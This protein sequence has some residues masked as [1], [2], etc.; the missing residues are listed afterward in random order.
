MK[1]TFKHRKTGE[2]AT[3]E[4]G[5]LKS[6]GFCVELGV[7]PS[8][9]LWE[10]VIEKDY[11]ILS[12]QY[13]GEYQI[14]T[15]KENIDSWMHPSCRGNWEIYSIKRLSD[16]E[17]FTVGDK[18]TGTLSLFEPQKGYV[19]ITGFRINNNKLEI[20]IETGVI[21]DNRDLT[22][23]DGSKGSFSFLTIKKCNSLFA[24]EDGYEIFVGDEYYIVM[25]NFT[26]HKYKAEYY[27]GRNGDTFK[28]F[29]EKTNAERYIF[30][31]K[32]VL[33]LKDVQS[34]YVSAKPGYKKNGVEQE[35]Y[36]KLCKLIKSKL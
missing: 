16:G 35:Y 10:E 28:Y 34:I 2:I 31:N 11:E 22:Y 14:I 21:T 27:S 30:E 26:L 8:S 29:K 17:V 19:K 6:S 1:K 18:I 36:D 25:Q 32:A 9:E 23:S 20:E 4:D 33:S 12:L 7:E 5:V 13:I 15:D 24:T 3:Y